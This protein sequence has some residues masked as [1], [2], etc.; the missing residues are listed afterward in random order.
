MQLSGSRVVASMREAL[1]LMP[2]PQKEIII[3]KLTYAWPT[4]AIDRFCNLED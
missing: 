2:V 3:K 4:H 1:G